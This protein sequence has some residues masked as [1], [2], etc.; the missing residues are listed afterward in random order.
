MAASSFGVLNVTAFHTF[1]C[2]SIG[3]WH[4]HVCDLQAMVLSLLIEVCAR[5]SVFSCF[6]SSNLLRQM[7]ECLICYSAA[8]MKISKKKKCIN[9]IKKK[10]GY[11]IHLN[12]AG[13][14]PW[15]KSIHNK[16]TDK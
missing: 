6:A 3:S 14:L 1:M 10:A 11:L 9:K 16:Q 4:Y 5:V 12:E 15:C 13:L 7:F 2:Q 8:A